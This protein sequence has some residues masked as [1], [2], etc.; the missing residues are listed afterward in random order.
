[1]TII[2]KAALIN[3]SASKWFLVNFF[4]LSS[5][6][7]VG[8]HMRKQS[9][10]TLRIEKVKREDAGTYVCRAQIRGRPS[11]FMEL[12]VSVVVNGK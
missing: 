9:D 4:C 12:S 10:N 11:I 6:A 5:L 7:S 8:G 2:A 1:M 3:I